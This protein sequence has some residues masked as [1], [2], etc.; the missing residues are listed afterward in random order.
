VGEVRQARNLD[1]RRPFG[2]CDINAYVI[3]DGREDLYLENVDVLRPEE[4][5]I[6]MKSLF[7]EEKLFHGKIREVL[8]LKH[9]V[10]LEEE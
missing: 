8:L 3:K 1:E 9:K 7:G 4:D 6:Y 2:M 10:V 5:G